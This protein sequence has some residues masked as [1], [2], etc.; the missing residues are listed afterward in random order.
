MVLAAWL[1]NIGNQSPGEA[2]SG[3][4]GRED[5]GSGHSVCRRDR[6]V[7]M[8]EPFDLLGMQTFRVI[9]DVGTRLTTQEIYILMTHLLL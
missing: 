6:S 8:A 7:R 9:S 3:V 4:R 1:L 5:H 2:V